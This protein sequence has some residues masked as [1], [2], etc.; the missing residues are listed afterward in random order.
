MYP[1]GHA[2]TLE[3]LDDP[4]RIRRA[5]LRSRELPLASIGRAVDAIYSLMKRLAWIAVLLAACP[6]LAQP[7]E[8]RV[9]GVR[10]VGAEAS[11]W[12]NSQA[13]CDVSDHATV[14]VVTAG[15]AATV[16]LVGVELALPSAPDAWRELRADGLFTRDELVHA[17]PRPRRSIRVR[18]HAS[19]D[20]TVYHEGAPIVEGMV[21]RV[22]LRVNGRAVTVRSPVVVYAEHPDPEFASP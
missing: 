5:C 4:N 20:V 19:T 3:Q 6:A 7:G 13:P 14:R 17:N 11:C 1:A 22:R 2:P 8:A 16:E 9:G 15:S 12:S 18:A 10:V 21:Y